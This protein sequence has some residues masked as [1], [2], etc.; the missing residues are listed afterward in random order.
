MEPMADMTHTLFSPR[1]QDGPSQ[2]GATGR[3]NVFLN[4]VSGCR[5]GPWR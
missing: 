2:A 3:T 4:G 5:W 1:L